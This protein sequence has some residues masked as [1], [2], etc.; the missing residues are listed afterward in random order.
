MK[1]K[2][3]SLKFVNFYTSNISAPTL[4]PLMRGV[5]PISPPD[6][7][8]MK[9]KLYGSVLLVGGGLGVPGAAAA[10]TSRLEMR[11]PQSSSGTVEVFT[12]PRVR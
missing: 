1:L 9:K 6:S 10:L 12:N 8:D 5:F 7:P 4:A 2:N 3:V 11:V